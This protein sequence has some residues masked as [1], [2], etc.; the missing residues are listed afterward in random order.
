MKSP[1]RR[2][3]E[4]PKDDPDNPIRLFRHFRKVSLDP[5][6]STIERAVARNAMMDC[7]SRVPWGFAAD[8][9]DMT[10]SE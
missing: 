7:W 5:A 3:S 4:Q 9:L 6:R 1:K 8:I 10:N 2:K